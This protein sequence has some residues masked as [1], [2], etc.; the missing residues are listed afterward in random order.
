M[1]SQ[2]QTSLL[3]NMSPIH[4]FQFRYSVIVLLRA[5]QL[6]FNSYATHTLLVDKYKC[7]LKSLRADVW[8]FV[9]V[10]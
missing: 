8:A 6:I 4:P 1:S 2:V 10:A 9:G 5:V 7:V 3:C